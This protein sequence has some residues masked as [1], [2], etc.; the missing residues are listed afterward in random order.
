VIRYFIKESSSSTVLVRQDMGCRLEIFHSWVSSRGWYP[1]LISV[2]ILL[3]EGYEELP[4][5]EILVK[6]KDHPMTSMI[7]GAII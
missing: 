1:K 6:Y 2:E 5:I 7:Y 3:A 4:A